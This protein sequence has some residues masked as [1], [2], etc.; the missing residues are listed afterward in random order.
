MPDTVA[1]PVA[2]P[3]PFGGG[4]VAGAVSLPV[5]NR[6]QPVIAVTGG[7]TAELFCDCMKSAMRPPQPLE[8]MLLGIALCHCVVWSVCEKSAVGRSA[9]L[10]LWYT[11]RSMGATRLPTL[12]STAA[13]PWL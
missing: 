1:M 4:T 9:R 13:L 8:A 11:V 3:V 7:K 12:A 10:L 5:Q 6:P 2:P